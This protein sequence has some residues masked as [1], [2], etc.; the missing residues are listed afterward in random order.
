MAGIKSNLQRL[1]A[2]YISEKAQRRAEREERRKAIAEEKAERKAEREAKQEEKFIIDYNIKQTKKLLKT[3]FEIYFDRCSWADAD[4]YLRTKEGVE[5]VKAKVKSTAKVEEIPIKL[6]MQV[7]QEVSKQYKA[8]T[9]YNQRQDLKER[10]K[11]EELK[12]NITKGVD[13]AFKFIKFILL[14]PIIFIYIFWLILPH[15]GK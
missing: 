8:Q 10:I 3:A 9:E 7:L 13:I 2:E 12:Q 1:T 4:M 5:K 6:Y 14:F 11:K 15:K